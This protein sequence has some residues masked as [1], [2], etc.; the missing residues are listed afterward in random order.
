MEEHSVV[1]KCHPVALFDRRRARQSEFATTGARG[2]QSSALPV[3]T[4]T[5]R[6]CLLQARGRRGVGDVLG[7]DMTVASRFGREEPHDAMIGQRPDRIHERIDE[8]AVV[9][10]PP[11]EDHVHDI[12]VV[13]IDE[14]DALGRHKCLAQLSVG[15]AVSPDLP[16]DGTGRDAQG[17]EERRSFAA[18]G[19]LLTR[20][21]TGVVQRTTGP[22]ATNSGVLMSAMCPTDLPD[23]AAWPSRGPLGSPTR[24]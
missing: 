18:H 2:D 15:V 19:R 17:A 14:F 21:P 4:G 22:S 12:V 5:H 11:D 7:F 13:L 24:A 6:G 1:A 9:L 8:I 20:R 16:D 3:A 10:A 23:W